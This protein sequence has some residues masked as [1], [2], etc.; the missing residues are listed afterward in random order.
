VFLKELQ[1]VGSKKSFQNLKVSKR[2]SNNK[3]T[4]QATKHRIS[5]LYCLTSHCACSHQNI[6]KSS[7]KTDSTSNLTPPQRTQSLVEPQK[8][9]LN[10]ALK[11]PPKKIS[12]SEKKSS[13]IRSQ[14]TIFSSKSES[15]PLLNRRNRSQSF[16]SSSDE[17]SSDENLDVF[18][19][20]LFGLNFEPESNPHVKSDN[21]NNNN[22]SITKQNRIHPQHSVSMNQPQSQQA[23]NQRQHVSRESSQPNLR[24]SNNNNRFHSFNEV[25]NQTYQNDIKTSKG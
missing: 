3:G 4:C 20:L 21:N 14:S 25:R 12:P 15:Q 16:S 19:H 24:Q 5:K 1:R 18:R 8:L 10:T 6:T 2:N 13:S 22:K 7:S 11:P 9:S 23:T 17:E